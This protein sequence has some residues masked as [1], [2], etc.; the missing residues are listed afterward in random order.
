[1]ELPEPTNLLFQRICELDAECATTIIE[2]IILNTDDRDMIRL[3]FCPDTVL[4]SF[5]EDAKS[6][7]GITEMVSSALSP[8]S[9]SDP[10][11]PL[12]VYRRDP[13]SRLFPSESYSDLDIQNPMQFLSLED[14]FESVNTV[15]LRRFPLKICHY[16]SKGYCKHGSKCRYFH[17]QVKAAHA[18]H[19]QRVIL[20]GKALENLEMEIVGLLKS[21]RGSPISIASLPIVYYEFYGK[22]LQ[23]DGYLTEGRGF[24]RACFSLTRLLSSLNSI[25]VLDRPHGQHSLILVEDIGKYIDS[26]ENIARQIYITFPAASTF[27]EQDVSSYF[28]KYG[29]VQDVKIPYQQSRMYGF[30]TFVYAETA[31]HV[32]SIRTTHFVCGAQVLVKPYKEKSRL[33]QRNN[34][35]NNREGNMEEANSMPRATNDSLTRILIDENELQRQRS[36]LFLS[37]VDSTNEWTH[38]SGLEGPELEDLLSTD[39]Q[40]HE[41]L[42]SLTDQA[43]DDSTTQEV[44]LP[45]SLFAAPTRR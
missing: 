2:Y 5:I 11:L 3:A 24:G 13:S 38:S 30:V 25:C 26:S 4:Q 1:M 18:N 35:E 17:G 39:Q 20:R 41:Q 8:V 43:D 19:E 44:D 42:P 32:L 9:I 16:F 33:I 23:A 27:T 36:E 40:Q 22:N 28:D 6:D 21:R 34:A 14:Q 29:P 7:L 12:S 45:E 31:R 10:Y 37:F 15:G